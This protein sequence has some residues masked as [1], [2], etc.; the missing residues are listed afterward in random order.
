MSKIEVVTDVAKVVV[1]IEVELKI[2][3]DARVVA[4]VCSLVEGG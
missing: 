3:E 4:G 1:L 2:V